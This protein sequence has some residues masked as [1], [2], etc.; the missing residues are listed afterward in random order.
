[1]L[2]PNG[3]LM[4]VKS[5]FVLKLILLDVL[6]VILNKFD[7]ESMRE[8]YINEQEIFGILKS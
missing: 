7:R 2:S 1:M 4:L 6:Y 8:V 5:S 3:I